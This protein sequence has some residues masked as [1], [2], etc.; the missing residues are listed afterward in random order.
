MNS[1][2]SPLNDWTVKDGRMNSSDRFEELIERVDEII[3]SSGHDLIHG[4]SRVVAGLIMAQ[5]AHEHGLAP[6]GS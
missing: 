4:R 5:L 6:R 3:R 1:K 2:L